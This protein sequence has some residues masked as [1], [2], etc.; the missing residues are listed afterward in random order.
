MRVNVGST[1]SPQGRGQGE[2][3]G[4]KVALIDLSKPARPREITYATLDARCNAVAAGLAAHRLGR[5]DR[6][7]PGVQ[8]GVG[9][10]AGV[11]GI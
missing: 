4:T 5:G 3:W 6:V 10:L 1:L 7:A 2:G 9:D 11:L 8:R